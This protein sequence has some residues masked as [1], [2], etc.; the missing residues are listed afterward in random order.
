L[1]QFG[2]NTHGLLYQSSGYG[3]RGMGSFDLWDRWSWVPGEGIW[4]QG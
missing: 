4:Y 2:Y 1:V 3:D